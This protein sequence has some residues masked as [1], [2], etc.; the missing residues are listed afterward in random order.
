MT[1][2]FLVLALLLSACGPAHR[3]P[4]LSDFSQPS[5]VGPLRVL[6]PKTMDT[7]TRQL[8]TDA[9]TQEYSAVY[10]NITPPLAVLFGVGSPT[11]IRNVYVYDGNY[12]ADSGPLG[13]TGYVD[14]GGN[15]FVAA[16]PGDI[17][18]TAIEL[19]TQS[20]YPASKTTTI[21][22]QLSNGQ[23]GSF[24]MYVQSVQDQVVGRLKFQRNVP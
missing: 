9:L 7:P 6:F 4:D 11:G 24:W 8:V 20:F 1:R 16:G 18:P 19:I 14:A 15:I 17:C 2:V 22:V 13:S 3:Q 10:T 12:V 5:F 21:N 23:T